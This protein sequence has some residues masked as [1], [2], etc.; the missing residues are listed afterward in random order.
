[1]TAAII[2]KKIWKHALVIQCIIDSKYY[3]TKEEANLNKLV[4]LKLL[5]EKS[6]DPDAYIRFS[7]IDFDI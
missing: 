2:R 6:I 1:M 3:E 4:K 7:F 5:Y